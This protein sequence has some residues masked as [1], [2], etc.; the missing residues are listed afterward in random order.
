M[1][2]VLLINIF[3]NS[4]YRSSHLLGLKFIKQIKTTKS[5]W[6]IGNFYDRIFNIKIN[7][8]VNGTLF[9]KLIAGSFLDLFNI[10]M[11]GP[12]LRHPAKETYHA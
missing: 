11:V 10:Q 5:C 1:Y 2:F 6:L 12:S 4:R 3:S 8:S 7:D 9:I